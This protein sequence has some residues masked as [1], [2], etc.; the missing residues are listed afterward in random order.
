VWFEALAGDSVSR[1]AAAWLPALLDA[2]IKGTVLLGIVGLSMLLMRRATAAARHLV[3]FLAAAS[4]PVL[5][6]LSVVSPEWHVLPSWMAMPIEVGGEAAPARGKGPRAPVEAVAAGDLGNAAADPAET[7][8]GTPSHPAG[9]YAH[10]HA[11]AASGW[12]G[13]AGRRC[14]MAGVESAGVVG[15]DGDCTGAVRPGDAESLVAAAHGGMGHRRSLDFAARPV[16]RRDRRHPP[17]GPA[18]QQP[19]VDAHALG[20]PAAEATGSTRWFGW[21]CGGCTWS[22]RWPATT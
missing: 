7:R 19:A 8:R 10:G 22:K 17:G 14:A 12:A 1:V 18:P 15:W 20:Y 2:A 21:P 16:C 6:V 3:W 11:P 9:C 4:L 5:P 13:R